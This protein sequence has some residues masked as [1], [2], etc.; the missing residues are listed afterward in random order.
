L[1]YGFHDLV[2]LY[3]RE[4]AHAESPAPARDRA[5]RRALGAWLYLADRA[6][7]RITD[8]TFRPAPLPARR[9]RVPV[10]PAP[11]PLAWFEAESAALRDAVGQAVAHGLDDVAMALAGAL[12]TFYELRDRYDV[13]RYTHQVALGAAE[14][15]GSRRG[16]AVLMRNLAYLGNIGPDRNPERDLALARGARDLSVDLGDRPG[17]ADALILYGHALRHLGDTDAALAAFDIGLSIA[18]RTGHWLGEVA[19]CHVSAIVRR[20]RGQPDAALAL[21]ARGLH[22]AARHDNTYQRVLLLRT[23]GIIERDE[24]RTELAERHLRDAL[25]LARQIQVPYEEAFITVNLGGLEAAAGRP[26]A[27]ARLVFGLALSR[28]RGLTFVEAVA[29]R[30]L[31]DLDR[32]EGRPATA[33]DNLTRALA[34]WRRLRVPHG[35]AL[36]LKLLGRAQ[37]ATGDADAARDSWRQAL[38]L[39]ERLTNPAE[40]TDVTGLLAGVR[41]D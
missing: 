21:L 3:A 32:A 18:R 27:L 29:L 15:A 8:R 5:V 17:E 16:R 10:E 20:E 1:R 24:G 6:D 13:W 30:T 22:L 41:A 39:F 12:L 31:G 35:E 25:R 38:A 4:R 11:T 7:A 36:T 23:A 33:V 28:A 37:A 9:C 40:V 14:R 19:L 26:G 34:L 2:R